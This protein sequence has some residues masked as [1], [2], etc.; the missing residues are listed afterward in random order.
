MYKGDIPEDI[1]EELL[2]S[3]ENIEQIGREASEEEKKDSNLTIV[4]F[5]HELKVHRESLDVWKI[6]DERLRDSVPILLQELDDLYFVFDIKKDGRYVFPIHNMI[7]KVV[8][9]TELLIVII[10]L[11]C[12]IYIFCSLQSDCLQTKMINREYYIHSRQTVI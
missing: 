12:I 1:I 9:T 11:T 7:A 10:R 8:G 6:E 2:N 4:W 3:F 5:L